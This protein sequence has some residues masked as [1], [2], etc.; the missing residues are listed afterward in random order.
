MA[1]R[2]FTQTF[3]VV[4]AVI[5]KE[6]KFLLVQESRRKGSE[7][8]QWNHPAGWIDVGEDPIEAVKRETKEETGYDFKP[9]ALLGLYSIVKRKENGEIRHAI[10]LVFLGTISRKQEKLA[11]D[12]LDTKWFSAEEINNMDKD[13]LR[14]ADIKKILRDFSS[15]QHFPL[16]ILTHSLV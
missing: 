13:T 2:V 10:K 4:A 12:I 7:H 9:S 16:K 5:E 3:G 11:D 14:D 6:G 1:E 15:G 8:G